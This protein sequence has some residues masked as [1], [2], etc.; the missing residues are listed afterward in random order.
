MPDSLL[1]IEAWA[2]VELCHERDFGADRAIG[3]LRSQM[4]DDFFHRSRF[5]RPRLC[6]WGPVTLRPLVLAIERPS[7][8]AVC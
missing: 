1:R 8:V 4:T 7:A 3:H 6:Y 2:V 5:V